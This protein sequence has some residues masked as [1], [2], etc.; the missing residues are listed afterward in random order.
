[1]RG[2][3]LD[4]RAQFR[5]RRA[6]LPTE[7]LTR[8]RPVR[9]DAHPTSPAPGAP[10]RQRGPLGA[11]R[12]VL[13]VAGVQPGV[14]WQ[15]G[16]TACAR[17]RRSACRMCPAGVEPH[18]TAG[19]PRCARRPGISSSSTASTGGGTSPGCS[20]RTVGP[21]A[22]G[23]WWRTT[24]ARVKQYVLAVPASACRPLPG[25]A[26]NDGPAGAVTRSSRVTINLLA[27]T[28][29]PPTGGVGHPPPPRPCGDPWRPFLPLSPPGTPI[30]TETSV[31]CES[32][33]NMVAPMSSWLS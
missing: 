29:S 20:T 7:R 12:R 24:P 25:D 30:S 9:P 28:A 26:G 10:L 22:G 5:K 27:D 21:T 4:H 11:Q 14:V 33:G 6:E 15:A 32:P 17:R 19:V 31:P 1:M 13:A 18:D 16:R 2:V 3:T 8:H 23:A